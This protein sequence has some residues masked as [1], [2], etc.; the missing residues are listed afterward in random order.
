VG[1]CGR[2][3]GPGGRLFGGSRRHGAGAFI[4]ALIA[5]LLTDR[6]AQR[7]VKS[8]VATASAGKTA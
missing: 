3:P 5:A 1:L 6:L 8:E 2:H 4:A 7:G